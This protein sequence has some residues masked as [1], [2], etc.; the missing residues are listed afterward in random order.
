LDAVT[1]SLAPFTLLVVASLA[2]YLPALR[3]VRIDPAL[4]L[5]ND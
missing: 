1:F 3:A 4:T 5:R 2:C